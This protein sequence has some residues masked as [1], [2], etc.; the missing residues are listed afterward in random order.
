MGIISE[1]KKAW[2]HIK[3]CENYI[4][5]SILLYFVFLG[6][7]FFQPQVLYDETHSLIFDDVADEEIS[8]LNF[9]FHNL[10]INLYKL[11]LGFMFGI[12]PFF[13]T[14][15]NGYVIGF[16]ISE[17]SELVTPSFLLGF[18]FLGFLELSAGF[19][20]GGLGLKSATF[21]FKKKKLK[22]LKNY[23]LNNVR[24]GFL[25]VMPILFISAIIE[26]FIIMG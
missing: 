16:G 14:L 5:F 4:Y 19:I 11:F 26:Y 12:V 8:V 20:A 24:V 7:G 17:V 18:L 9:F 1:Y 2:E 10:K 23:L 15:L 25:I 3:K 13:I 6:I 22:T 21:I